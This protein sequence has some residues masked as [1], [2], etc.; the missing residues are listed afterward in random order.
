MERFDFL[1]D[2]V[3]WRC[4]G[5]E[6]LRKILQMDKTLH[7]MWII[8]DIRPVGLVRVFLDQLRPF[9]ELPLWKKE[10]SHEIM[11]RIR[12][13]KA[14]TFRILARERFYLRW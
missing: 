14:R 9:K 1:C 13:M 5:Y 12:R 2:V 10:M 4:L 8:I 11:L 7:I 6:F 3:V